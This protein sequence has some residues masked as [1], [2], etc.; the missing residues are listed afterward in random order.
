MNW[1][2]IKVNKLIFYIF[3][4]ILIYRVIQIG[5]KNQNITQNMKKKTK[6]EKDPVQVP[7]LLLDIEN[8]AQDRLIVIEKRKWEN[9]NIW[10]PHLLKII[11]N[12][13]KIKMI[14][15]L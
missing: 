8:K 10:V 9:K 7:D 12:K 5:W 1:I 6:R 11:S 15:Y 13:I 14:N 4:L 2:F 3:I